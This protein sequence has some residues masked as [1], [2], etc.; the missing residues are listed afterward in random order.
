MIKAIELVRQ[1]VFNS[2]Y[3]FFEKI[4]KFHNAF[5]VIPVRM[6]EVC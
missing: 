6:R 2:K 5:Y 4:T 1:G 3:G